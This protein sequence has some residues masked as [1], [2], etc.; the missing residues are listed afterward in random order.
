[1]VPL[2]WLV[3]TPWLPWTLERKPPEMREAAAFSGN[4]DREVV[5]PAVVDVLKA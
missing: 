5:V 3:R 1:M 4:D 2:V